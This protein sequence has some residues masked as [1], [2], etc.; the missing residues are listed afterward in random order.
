VSFDQLDL[1][2]GAAASVPPIPARRGA[3]HHL[4]FDLQGGTASTMIGH[5]RLLSLI[6][7][8]TVFPAQ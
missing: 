7:V 4:V 8:L 2:A 5:M 1:G 3:G 6:V